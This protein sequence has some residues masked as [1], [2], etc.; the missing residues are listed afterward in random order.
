ME[1][2][3][4]PE[5]VCIRVRRKGWIEVAAYQQRLHHR[6]AAGKLAKMSVQAKK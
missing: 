1:V 4:L 5:G 2:R 6:I 3:R